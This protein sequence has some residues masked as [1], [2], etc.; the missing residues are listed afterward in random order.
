MARNY[1]QSPLDT[2]ND[3]FGQG[4]DRQQAVTDRITTTR[5]G[6]ALAGGD[7]EGAASTFARGGM[8][9]Q[10]R[11]IQGD[12][13][14]ADDRAYE[15]STAEEARAA[16]MKAQQAQALI[17]I[18]KGLQ[19]VP[20]GQRATMLQQ[21][22]PIFKQ[23]GVDPTPFASLTEDQLSDDQLALF[24][25]EMEKQWQVLNLGN[26]GAAQ[27]NTR[28]GEFKT[29][30]EPDPPP[31]I[32]GNGAI[33]VDRQDGNVIARNA[34]TFA[35]ARGGGGRGGGKAAPAAPRPTGRHF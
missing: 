16:K 10:A 18:A 1:F 29:L 15:R 30:R 23:I 2:A 4:Y 3:A 25:G 22:L 27:Y 9:P 5:A 12:A 35:P 34:K 20:Q 11:Q 28:T 24:A 7:R 33:A 6:Q 21:S 19:G 8:I 32:V 31:V 14:A 17:T 26:G 13:Q